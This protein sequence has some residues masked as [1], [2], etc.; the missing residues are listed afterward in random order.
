MFDE[1]AER[2]SVEF[3]AGDLPLKLPS[4]AVGVEDSG[5]E[6]IGEVVNKDGALY[7]VG[8]TGLE[9]VLYGGGVAGDDLA[10]A[11]GA[12]EGESGGR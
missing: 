9:N 11:Q 8:E 3:V 7:I 10:A 6:E 1:F 12:V 5:A 4:V 2:L